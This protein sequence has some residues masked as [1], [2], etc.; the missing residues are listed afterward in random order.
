MLLDY[1]IVLFLEILRLKKD[2]NLRYSFWFKIVD[3]F[4]QL[5]PEV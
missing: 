4:E 1:C 5:C 3:L 2:V